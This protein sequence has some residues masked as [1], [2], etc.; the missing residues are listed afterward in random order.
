MPKYWIADVCFRQGSHPV[1]GLLFFG[2]ILSDMWFF[3]YGVIS[4]LSDQWMLLMLISWF[5]FFYIFRIIYQK[6]DFVIGN[7]VIL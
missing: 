3:V 7:L 5:S 2:L 6:K 4:I 1:T